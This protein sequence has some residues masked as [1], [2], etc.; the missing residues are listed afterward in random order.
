[1][2]D[3]VSRTCFVQWLYMIGGDNA[4]ELSKTNSFDLHSITE[5]L[6]TKPLI[7]EAIG[8]QY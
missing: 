8:M 4:S 7:T 3:W 1:M 2:D 5:L 6:C